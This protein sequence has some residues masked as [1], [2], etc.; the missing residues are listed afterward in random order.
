V[1]YFKA[2]RRKGTFSH[3]ENRHRLSPAFREFCVTDMFS[4]ASRL[5]PNSYCRT[6]CLFGPP[7]GIHFERGDAEFMTDIRYTL[8]TDLT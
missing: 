1:V 2:F 5:K 7:P 6:S 8:A 4:I 3:A